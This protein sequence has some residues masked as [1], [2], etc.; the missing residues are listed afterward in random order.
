M[1]MGERRRGVAGPQ[2]SKKVDFFF[3]FFWENVGEGSFRKVVKREN[4][5]TWK[6]MQKEE[7]DIGIDRAQEI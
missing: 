5:R 3:F 4:Y 7:M 2:G 1:E 6:G